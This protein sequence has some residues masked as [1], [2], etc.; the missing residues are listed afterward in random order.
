VR[1]PRA[2]RNDMSIGEQ[3]ALVPGDQCTEAAAESRGLMKKPQMRTKGSSEV[4]VGAN[5][6]C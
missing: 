4:A 5:G 6:K 1:D 3:M 2:L